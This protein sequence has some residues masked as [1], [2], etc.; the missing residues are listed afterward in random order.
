MRKYANE[1]EYEPVLDCEE[2]SDEDKELEEYEE[3]LDELRR[4]P[5]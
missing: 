4:N 2:I 1:D 5:L 3:T